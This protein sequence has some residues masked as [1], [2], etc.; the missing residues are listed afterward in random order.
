MHRGLPPT[1]LARLH[2]PR[3]K[4]RARFHS[5][6]P[7]CTPVYAR[8]YKAP[9]K[10]PPPVPSTGPRPAS[11]MPRQHG[12]SRHNAGTTEP[13]GPPRPPPASMAGC[14]HASRKGC[15][16]SQFRRGGASH[17]REG[18]NGLVGRVRGEP[19]AWVVWKE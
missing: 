17:A 8:P 11:S 9:C 12:S 6:P 13:T 3:A 19:D 1:P 18:Q 4:P 10:A 2:I 16:E 15:R 7:R 5:T 14:P